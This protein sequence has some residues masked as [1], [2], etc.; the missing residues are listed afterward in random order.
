M[1]FIAAVTTL[2]SATLTSPA[3]PTSRS[4]ITLSRI[5]N[6]RRSNPSSATAAAHNIAISLFIKFGINTL[7]ASLFLH[8]TSN[9]RHTGSALQSGEAL[10]ASFVPG[11]SWEH[12]QAVFSTWLF[13]GQCA[14]FLESTVGLSLQPKHFCPMWAG[15]H[16][17]ERAS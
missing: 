9:T 2:L 12:E 17:P 10:Y 5:S 4:P 6:Y 16:C 3:S 14:P 15:R 11:Q 7:R 1:D 13:P 8:R